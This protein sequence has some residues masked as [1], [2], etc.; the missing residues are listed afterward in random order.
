M[1]LLAALAIACSVPL[2][3]VGEEHSLVDPSSMT[4]TGDVALDDWPNCNFFVVHTEQGFSL[5][6]WQSGMWIFGEGDQVYGHANQ[7]GQQSILLAG[8]VM[9]GHMTVEI[10]AV[11]VDLARAQAAFYKRCKI[12]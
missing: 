4:Q 10:E 6:M 11:G 7:I 12:S 8:I 1:N 2:L 3:Q 9:S 5:V